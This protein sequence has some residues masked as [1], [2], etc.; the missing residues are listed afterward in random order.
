LLTLD[1]YRSQ[2]KAIK[3]LIDEYLRDQHMDAYPEW[4]NRNIERL[5]ENRRILADEYPQHERTIVLEEVAAMAAAK[6]VE[7]VQ[8]REFGLDSVPL[9]NPMDATPTQG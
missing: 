9:N 8:P 6:T 1:Q 4:R 7:H 5:E 2:R 3:D